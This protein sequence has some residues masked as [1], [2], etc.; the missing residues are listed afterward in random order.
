MT[1]EHFAITAEMTWD[2]VSGEP[3]ALRMDELVDL[4]VEAHASAETSIVEMGR[5][6]Y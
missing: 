1:Q 5:I 2:T 4:K 3:L 6:F